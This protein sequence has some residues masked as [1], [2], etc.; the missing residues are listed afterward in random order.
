MNKLIFLLGL[1]SLSFSAPVNDFVDGLPGMNDDK[2]FPFKSYSGYLSVAGT[3]RSLHYF[4]VESQNDPTN[5]PVV[6]W[7]NG[8]PGCSSMLGL[9]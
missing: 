2:P 8:G 7:F 5:D 3:T 6:V 1:I 9:I 4:Y